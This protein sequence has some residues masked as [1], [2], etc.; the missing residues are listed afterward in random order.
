MFSTLGVWRQCRSRGVCDA[1]WLLCLRGRRQGRGW[2]VFEGP[3]VVDDVVPHQ[4]AATEGPPVD[5]G[6]AERR[7]E[8]LVLW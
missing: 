2:S 8:L 5:N 4:R 1:G 3:Q 7:M 6:D